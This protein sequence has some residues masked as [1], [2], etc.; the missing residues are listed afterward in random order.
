MK[1][2][3]VEF[4]NQV[5][6]TNGYV[7]IGSFFSRARAL[8]FVHTLEFFLTRLPSPDALHR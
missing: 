8:Q 6:K 3:Q 7:P 4:F 5:E 2:D 1:S